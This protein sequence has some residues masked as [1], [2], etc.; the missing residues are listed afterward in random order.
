MAY[1]ILLERLVASPTIHGIKFE[2][3]KVLVE[4]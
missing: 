1:D 4:L 3:Y 2:K